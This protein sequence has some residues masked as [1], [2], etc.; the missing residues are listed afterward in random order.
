M[1]LPFF[2]FLFLL[3]S[4]SFFA[5]KT[6]HIDY[7][8]LGISFDTP[9][10]WMGQETETGYIFTSHT[11]A[12]MIII[13]PHDE[14]HTI[15]EVEAYANSGINEGP[16]NQLTLTG[17]LEKFG[18]R[19]IGGEFSG[20]IDWT[21]VNAFVVAK[22]NPYGKGV[23]IIST[24]TPEQYNANYRKYAVELANSIQ[25]KQAAES[26][27]LKQFRQDLTG[28]KIKHL[29][30][31]GDASNGGSTKIE[32]DL[33]VNGRFSYYYSAFSGANNANE[34]SDFDISV[35]SNS[36]DNKLGNWAIEQDGHGNAYLILNCENGEVIEYDL[37]YQN[38]TDLHLDDTRYY[39]IGHA[40]CY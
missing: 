29:N 37:S 36:Q 2:T 5:Q 21:K 27:A 25:Y 4:T 17:K 40:Q 28:A 13:L 33:C 19:A 1:K 20:K 12:G 3:F 7:E 10:G 34:I 22:L 32:M 9:E 6:G 26:Q 24:T 14:Q 35:S 15:E 11:I 30:T 31:F 16:G 38:G 18:T 8:Y 39:N 23:T